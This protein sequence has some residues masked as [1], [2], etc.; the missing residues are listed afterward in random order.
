[1]ESKIK[2]V[3]PVKTNEGYM[4]IP[5]NELQYS[6][7]DHYLHR[8][9]VFSWGDKNGRTFLTD[10]RRNIV[11][12]VDMNHA[13]NRVDN[14]ELVSEGINLFRAYYKTMS[15]NCKARFLDYYNK[16]DDLDKR[17]LDKEIDM[18]IEGKY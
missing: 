9:V 6:N 16:L 13:N 12:H 7:K 1:M 15:S 5:K 2:R 8:M 3:E 4:T 10:Q 14:L 18:D 11:D 17:I